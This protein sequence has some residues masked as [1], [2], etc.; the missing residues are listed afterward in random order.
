LSY[1]GFRGA[2]AD[3]MRPQT[4]AAVDPLE[5]IDPPA[6]SA[7]E[8]PRVGS[9]PG[10]TL[11]VL[12]VALV[13][14][15]GLLRLVFITHCDLS[16]DE[17]QHMHSAYLVSQGQT[18]FVDFFEHHMPLFYYLAAAVIPMRAPTFDT[19][20]DARYLS[21]TFNAL[22]IV[23][24]TLWMARLAGRGA[25]LLT[26]ALLVGNVAFL[27]WGAL[28]YLDTYAAPLLVLSAWLLAP[29]GGRPLR[30]LLS[31]ATLSLAVLISQKTAVAVLAAALV[32]LLRAVRE[33]PDAAR[34]RALLA[35]LAAYVV[36]GLVPVGAVVLLLGQQGTVGLLRDVVILNLHWKARHYPQRELSIL[37]GSD[38][39]IYVAAL[40]ALGGELRALVRRRFEPR[41][42]DVP[43]LF[44][45]AFI[46]GVFFIPVVWEEYFIPIVPFAVM[47][48]AIGVAG[49]W[50]TLRGLQGTRA[51]RMLAVWV[52]VALADLVGLWVAG[53]YTRR[54]GISPHAGVVTLGLWAILIALI[55]AARRRRIR[56]EGPLWAALL[57]AL[58][59]VQQVDWIPRHPFDGDRERVEY[60]MRTTRPTD[61]VLDGT[62]G[63]G[64]FR[65]HAYRYWFL[66]DEMQ[67]MLSER[68]KGPDVIRALKAPSTR[69]VIL[70]PYIQALPPAV[71]RFIATHYRDTPFPD[72][73]RRRD[74][75]SAPPET[76]RAPPGD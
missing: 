14:A 32:L 31:G 73:K 52:V 38:G 11:A 26:A 75:G 67:L 46:A 58:P 41:A 29:P 63:F 28:S 18:P 50:P 8:S 24:A 5:G 51:R 36:G 45:A 34:R 72:L 55:A 17:Y 13:L 15:G 59:V 16:Y 49:W 27:I 37:L 68:E 35:D 43:A 57:L 19:L 9:V 74:I 25:A 10:R 33:L 56:Q 30:A 1:R 22:A 65:P 4:A 53:S 12:L 48:A 42:E 62:S 44:L 6:V 64:V 71:L 69:I 61:A 47:V 21:L 7:D 60:I 20:I 2:V 54:W 40:V 66:H 39:P 76:E 3:R 23:L 70:D